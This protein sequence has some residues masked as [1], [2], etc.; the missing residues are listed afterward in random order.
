MG[1]LF[2]Q[3]SVGGVVYGDDVSD[4]FCDGRLLEDMVNDRANSVK[5]EEFLTMMS[6]CHTGDLVISSSY[7]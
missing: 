3:C 6:I 5:I 1:I 7:V 4:E 2:L